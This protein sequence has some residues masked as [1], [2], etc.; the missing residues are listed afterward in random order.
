[1]RQTGIKFN[2]F[3]YLNPMF[4]KNAWKMVMLIVDLIKAF[5][6]EEDEIELKTIYN[7]QLN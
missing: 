2:K 7:N 3:F 1:M 4:Y 6:E 5:T